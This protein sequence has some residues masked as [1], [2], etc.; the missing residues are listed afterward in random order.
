MNERTSDKNLLVQTPKSFKA[1]DFVCDVETQLPDLAKVRLAI[2]V[3]TRAS[4]KLEK[5]RKSIAEGLGMSGIFVMLNPKWTDFN[6]NYEKAVEV[7][8]G[9]AVEKEKFSNVWYGQPPL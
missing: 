1:I 2:Q 6:D 5:F 8:S 4:N 3:S 7:T 9:A